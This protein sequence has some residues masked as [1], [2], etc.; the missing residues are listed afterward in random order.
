MSFKRKF[1]TSISVSG[2]CLVRPGHIPGTTAT[3]TPQA[4]DQKQL[5][6]S[7]LES[8]ATKALAHQLPNCIC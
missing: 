1:A 3:W 2:G 4:G 7:E 8:A 6:T 5:L